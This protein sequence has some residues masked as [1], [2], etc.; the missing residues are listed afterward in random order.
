M[1]EP[2]VT[3]RPVS[4]STYQ[5]HGCRCDG[6]RAE[7]TRFQR[8]YRANRKPEQCPHN[9]HGLNGY[10][11]YGC[12]CDVCVESKR[13]DQLARS[14]AWRALAKRHPVEYQ[15]LLDIEKRKL[16]ER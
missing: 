13:V 1:S 12:R 5:R 2:H 8:K 9:Q 11:N 16:G 15:K 4:V 10:S 6:C 14:R 7:Q 3:G